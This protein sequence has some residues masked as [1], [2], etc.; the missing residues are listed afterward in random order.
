MVVVIRG[1]DDFHWAF[2]FRTSTTLRERILPQ[3]PKKELVRIAYRAAP[4]TLLGRLFIIRL[5]DFF[6]GQLPFNKKGADQ[7]ND[8]DERI[9]LT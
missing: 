2:V 3:I 1:E 9:H 5:A 8:K 4:A 6:D 7:A